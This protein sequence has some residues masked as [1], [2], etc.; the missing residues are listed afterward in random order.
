MENQ[1]NL[2]SN[3]NSQP[4]VNEDIE[5]T[6]KELM[7]LENEI[8]NMDISETINQLSEKYFQG[9][10]IN[11]KKEGKGLLIDLN[12]DIFEGIFINDKKEGFGVYLFES[13][14]KYVG[15]FKNDVLDGIGSY[16]FIN[17]SEY[18]GEINETEMHGFG[19]YH[20]PSGSYYVGDFNKG[21][22]D[23]IG[24][25]YFAGNER[26]EGEFKNDNMTGIGKYFYS[27]GD[28]FEGEFKNDFKN[29]IGITY[30]SNGEKIEGKWENDKKNGICLF[31][32][33]NGDCVVNNYK[34]NIIEGNGCFI[35]NLDGNKLEF[36]AENNKITKF[37]NLEKYL[38][39]RIRSSEAC[40]VKREDCKESS[41]LEKS[42]DSIISLEIKNFKKL[43]EFFDSDPKEIFFEQ[44]LNLKEQTNDLNLKSINISCINQECESIFNIDEALN[45][46]KVCQKI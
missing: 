17:G 5:L 21:E 46:L 16:F 27:D 42:D 39:I 3:A 36:V 8:K 26:Y 45:H 23:G 33:T 9:E 19:N 31:Y 32:F 29:G 10:L 6:E 35:D 43:F 22:M 28:Y 44:L 37:L 14:K 38:L 41:N 15:Q 20:Y 34:D 2:N 30:Y 40:N 4:N 13:G 1:D 18:Y 24:T 12:G 7:E 25:L 11:G